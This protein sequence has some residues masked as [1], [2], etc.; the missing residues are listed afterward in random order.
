[1]DSETTL[2]AEQSLV[3]VDADACLDAVGRLGECGCLL[4]VFLRFCPSVCSGEGVFLYS[5]CRRSLAVCHGNLLS[6]L[7]KRIFALQECRQ[8]CVRLGNGVCTDHGIPLRLCGDDLCTVGRVNLPLAADIFIYYSLVCSAV[9]CGAHHVSLCSR[10]SLCHA[11]HHSV[12]VL[13]VCTCSTN[14]ISIYHDVLSIEILVNQSVRHIGKASL[15]LC[16]VDCHVIVFV[17]L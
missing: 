12:E 2:V 5:H 15:L 4:L 17:A 7:C 9:C 16:S 3:H 14:G 6:V 10:R 11:C 13:S 8:I 1:M